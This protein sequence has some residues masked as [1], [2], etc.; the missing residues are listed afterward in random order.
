MGS[1]G[2]QLMKPQFD[3]FEA[4][5]EEWLDELSLMNHDESPHL[6]NIL[7]DLYYEG[8]TPLDA[9]DALEVYH[10]EWHSL[11]PARTYNTQKNKK[12]FR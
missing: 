12:D 6:K 7:V 3:L 9:R 4:T 2:V 10:P 8:L 1:H 5:F 11:V